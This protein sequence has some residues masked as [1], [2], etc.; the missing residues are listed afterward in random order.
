MLCGARGR[1]QPHIQDI[2]QII[3]LRPSARDLSSLTMMIL[4]AG[5]YFIADTHVTEQPTSTEMKEMA[6][7]AAEEARR[8][9]IEPRIAFLSHSNFGSSGHA[10]AERVRE[11]VALL[12]REHPELEADGEMHADAA[13]SAELRAALL[14]ASHLKSEANIL[15]MPSLDAANI[16]YNLLKMLGNGLSV[17]PMLIGAALPAHVLTNSATARGIVNMTA[18]AVV[19]A[20]EQA[21][22][23]RAP[24]RA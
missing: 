5:V 10:S 8:F 19:D 21:A 15:I 18:L 22:R 16:S 6:V 12:H 24:V 2:R 23:D 3:G 14:P 1:F 9:G 11:A 20:Q 17:G 7:M 4:D 13:L